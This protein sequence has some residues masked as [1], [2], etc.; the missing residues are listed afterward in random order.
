MNDASAI[1][2]LYRFYFNFYFNFYLLCIFQPLNTFID[3]GNVLVNL[4]PQHLGT[5]RFVVPTLPGQ[6]L[7]R[8][9]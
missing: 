6:C 9:R 7:L 1:K 8:I 2:A 4:L 3:F 5:F